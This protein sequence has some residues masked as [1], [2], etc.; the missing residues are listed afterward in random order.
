MKIII[1]TDFDSKGNVIA[2]HVIDTSIGPLNQVDHPTIPNT[3][4]DVVSF[5]AHCNAN[6]AQI[7]AAGYN[8]ISKRAD[9]VGLTRWQVIL[10]EIAN[11][12]DA[13]LKALN[14]V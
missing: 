3:K 1:D 13:A 14:L 6:R 7:S 11:S 12:N 10:R 2:H 4:M 9:A 5:L 8:V